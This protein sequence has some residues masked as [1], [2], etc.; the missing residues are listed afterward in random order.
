MA[1]RIDK[2]D[3]LEK[4][5]HT[6]KRLGQNKSVKWRRHCMSSN[7]ANVPMRSFMHPKSTICCFRCQPRVLKLRD[8]E[9]FSH[10]NQNHFTRKQK[11]RN[12]TSTT[13]NWQPQTKVDLTFKKWRLETPITAY[14]LN[15]SGNDHAFYPENIGC[16][17]WIE[18]PRLDVYWQGYNCPFCWILPGN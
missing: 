12:C 6:G 3:F 8:L 2:A 10:C 15:V 18:P 17:L 1:C 7:I 9:H 11:C 13:T 14:I 4:G 5:E 16:Q